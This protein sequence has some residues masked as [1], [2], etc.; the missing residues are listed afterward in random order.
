MYVRSLQFQAFGA[1]A[2]P[3]SIDFD[4]LTQSG[5]FLLEGPTGAGKSTVI[6]AIV[7]A[8][9]GGVAVSTASAQ[10]VRSDFAGPDTETVV[11]L[12][13]EVPS[14]IFRVRR[15]PQY[16]R[17]AKRVTK[18]GTGTTTQQASV[19]LWRLTEAGW[20]LARGGAGGA[21]A[22]LEHHDLDVAGELI[23]TRMDE[24]GAEITRAVGLSREQFV[25]TIVL[26]QGEFASFL[27][28]RPEERTLLL[29]RVFRTEL[30]VNAQNRFAELR[31][32]L[33]SSVDEARRS[34]ASAVETFWRSRGD[35]GDAIE[36]NSMDGLDDE[37]PETPKCVVTAELALAA[38]EAESQL[39]T[40]QA[41]ADRARAD[42]AADLLRNAT[43]QQEAVQRR[44]DIRAR[45]AELLAQSEVHGARVAALALA[46]RAAA[47]QSAISR[48][49]A[50]RAAHTQCLED[51]AQVAAKSEHVRLPLPSERVDTAADF[52]TAV[53]FDRVDGTRL[54]ELADWAA[55]SRDVLTAQGTRLDESSRRVMEL[56]TQSESVA[57]A[58]RAVREAQD[59]VS[60]AQQAIA[61]LPQRQLA[62]EE[63]QSDQAP[64]AAALP[65]RER[66]LEQAIA[67]RKELDILSDAVTQWRTAYAGAAAATMQVRDL[68]EVERALRDARVLGIAGEIASGLIEG[69]SC[70]V[71]GSEHHPH[72]A[73]LGGD[74]V[75][76]DQVAA[77]ELARSKA[78]QGQQAAVATA[79]RLQERR[80]A[81]AYGAG[82][83]LDS[84]ESDDTLPHAKEQA[85]VRVAA[86]TVAR[87]EA[88][89]AHMQLE[90]IGTELRQLAKDDARLRDV[91]AATQKLLAAR[92]ATAQLLSEQYLAEL[93]RL[94]AEV[95]QLWAELGLVA[96][97]ETS[98]EAAEPEALQSL[99]AEAQ[100]LLTAQTEAVTAVAEAVAKATSSRSDEAGRFADMNEALAE[101]GFESSTEVAPHLMSA[102]DIVTQ[103]AAVDAYTRDLQEADAALAVPEVATLP[104][105]FDANLADLAV[106]CADAART[107]ASAHDAANNGQ[108]RVIALT[109][110]LNSLTSAVDHYRE[111]TQGAATT[112]RVAD[113][114]TARSADNH[115]ALTLSTYVLVQRFETVVEAANQRLLVM[116]DGRY[117]LQRSDE[118]EKK[119]GRN[120][121]LA[122]RV[123]DH[124]TAKTRE[125]STLSGGETFYVSLCLALGLS[126]VVSA[127]AGGVE[128]GTL[129]VDEGFGTLD[130][131][132][133]E[134]VMTHLVQLRDAGRVVGLVSHVET[135]KQMI[136]ERIE[137]RRLSSG[138][139]TVRVIA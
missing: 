68:I 119:G 138:A 40:D 97:S 63:K 18:T 6:D 134:V 36:T 72:P 21:G 5:L 26:P 120:L 55:S 41:A 81:S 135:M 48:H 65:E 111:V 83:D 67:H 50:A 122:L 62:L 107:A 82:L 70:P 113:L 7:F 106:K 127:E 84:L 86:A 78:E 54:R 47:A 27:K 51:L 10:R 75:S 66:E 90:Q 4:A 129:F 85:E 57:A 104:E 56:T 117:E 121:G 116:S 77:A 1:F 92:E 3:I 87:D 14:G 8:L 124:I 38:L 115:R 15:T 69:Q 29:Q 44:D 126:D 49:Q 101:Q 110:A 45:R 17:A 53:D 76:A 12:V 71:C 30:Y 16:E 91:H 80:D 132:T 79:T 2:E 73:Q 35:D 96:D 43:V 88:H 20:E 25:Q 133:L 61:D 58:E 74:H 118:K 131:D 13:F 64:V 108:A 34:V 37:G 23:S 125:P 33:A 105:V 52:D 11:D 136:P 94:R 28:A 95:A 22:T 93:Q 42:E 103:Q 32:G 112:L 89:A 100:S 123:L 139:S 109:A 130:S 137:V 24:A 9:Y 60:V 102:A 39:L 31:R 128:F 46:A 114:V 99:V 19:K 59:E 98:L